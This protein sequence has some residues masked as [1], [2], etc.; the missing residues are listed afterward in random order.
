MIIGRNGTPGQARGRIAL[1]L[2]P[3]LTVQYRHPREPSMAT[4]RNGTPGQAPGRIALA[5]LPALSF[6][7]RQVADGN[8]PASSPSEP[9]AMNPAPVEGLSF[10]TVEVELPNSVVADAATADRELLALVAVNAVHVLHDGDRFTLS[11][12]EGRR[13]VTLLVRSA[14]NAH[15]VIEDADQMS[16]RSISAAVSGPRAVSGS[17]VHGEPTLEITHSGARGLR[18]HQVA[19]SSAFA[20]LDVGALTRHV[21]VRR[22]PDGGE[23]VGYAWMVTLTLGMRPGATDLDRSADLLLALRTRLGRQTAS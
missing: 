20:T 18:S 1:A 8:P 2:L 15:V 19:A 11:T 13:P 7:G 6:R 3:E 9:G 14:G 17:P 5:P 16:D 10:T 23:A 22:L 4:G 12:E 21:A